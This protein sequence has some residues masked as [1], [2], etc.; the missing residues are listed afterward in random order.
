MLFQIQILCFCET[1]SSDAPDIRRMWSSWSESR[2]CHE[3][4][5]GTGVPPCEDRL[6]E[7]GL[8]HL[9]KRRLH[10]DLIGIF[11]YLKGTTGKMEWDSSSGTVGIGQGKWVQSRGRVRLGI[12]KKLSTVVVLRHW[13][14]FPRE[15]VDVPGRDQD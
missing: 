5:E 4:D 2:G 1:Q 14:R 8:F 3:V 9:E 12:R 13:N 11:Q 15:A 6:R 10:G 7:L